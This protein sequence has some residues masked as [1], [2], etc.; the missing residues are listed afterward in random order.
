MTKVPTA[1]NLAG[2]FTKA[3]AHDPFTKLRRLVLNI[4]VQGVARHRC[5]VCGVLQPPRAL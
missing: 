1:D 2:M 4:L 5:R 3:L